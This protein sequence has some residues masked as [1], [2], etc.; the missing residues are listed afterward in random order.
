MRKTRFMSLLFLAWSIA[1]FFVPEF[2]QGA[3]MPI[4][5]SSIGTSGLLAKMASASQLSLESLAE[6][7]RQAEAQRDAKTLAFVALYTLDTR[8][9]TRVADLATSLDPTLTWI[10]CSLFFS[11][12]RYGVY[13][14]ELDKWVARLEAWD[15]DNG[16][17]YLM[18]AAQVWARRKIKLSP[19][20]LEPLAEE[21]EWRTAMQKVFAAPRYDSYALRRFELER[22]WLHRRHLDYPAVVLISVASYPI[23]DLLQLRSYSRLLVGKLGKEAEEAGRSAEALTLYWT[24]AH[25]GARMQ[26]QGLSTIEKVMGGTLQDLASERLLPLLRKTGRTDEALSLEYAR[27]LS[28]Q[29]IE[30]FRGK[31]P[32]TRSSNY[33]WAAILVHLSLGLIVVFGFLTIIAV[34][35]VNLKRWVRPEKKGRL[36]QVMTVMENYLPILLF[37]AC[38]GLYISYYPYARNF[39]Y[40][41]T[42][43]G[44]IHDLEPLFINAFPTLLAL[45]TWAFL[46]IGNPF[47]PYVW[48]ALTGLVV[49]VLIEILSRRRPAPTK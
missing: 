29:R 10:Y 31:D 14:P 2:R 35:Y 46:P 32:L 22:E 34:A 39:Q 23:P 11:E 7:A 41:M 24:A 4:L 48:Y 45:P 37:L 47:E 49:A 8:E 30:A 42:A 27:E 28:R 3:G 15:P 21:T 33:Y 18:E 38:L 6:A 44:P 40:Y 36:Y 16:F 43:S 13:D 9:R 19:E 5:A 25:M 17:P 12:R 20:Q 26:V 1:F